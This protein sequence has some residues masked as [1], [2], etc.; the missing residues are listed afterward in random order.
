MSR[1]LAET[2]GPPPM[3][4]ARPVRMSRSR[5]GWRSVNM[6]AVTVPFVRSPVFAVL[7]RARSLP[8]R[9]HP[10]A[11]DGGERD[12]ASAEIAPRTAPSGKFETNPLL[13]QIAGQVP[14][15]V[16]LRWDARVSGAFRAKRANLA[17]AKPQRQRVL[18]QFGRNGSQAVELLKPV[19][20][21]CRIST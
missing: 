19:Q 12:G 2:S 3:R 14:T 9:G 21:T 6:G 1:R 8:V 15:P 18:R 17:L 5:R 16:Q 7:C 11:S 4:T 20:S 13:A 10:A